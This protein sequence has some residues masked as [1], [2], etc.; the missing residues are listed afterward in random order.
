M[1]E[2]VD[3]KTEM[4]RTYEEDGGRQSCKKIHGMDTKR[5]TPKRKFQEEVDA[6][7]EGKCLKKR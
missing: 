1:L 6:G 4:V 3:S 5:E 7:D 2:E